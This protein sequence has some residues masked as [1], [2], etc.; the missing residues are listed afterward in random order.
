MIRPALLEWSANHDHLREVTRDDVVAHVKTLQGRERHQAL[1]ALRSLFAWA[2]KNGVIF[3][4]PTSQIKVGQAAAPVLQPL[5]PAQVARSAEAVT[6][7]AGRLAVALAA[8]HAA[9]PGSIRALQLDDTDLGN[10]RITIAGRTNPLDDLTRQLLLAWL[11]HRRR[12]WPNTANS[13]LIINM[14]TALATVPVS[15]WWIERELR[16]QAATLDRLRIDR[17]LE[18]ALTHGP[19]PLHLAEVFGLDEKTTMRYADSARA[20][21]EQAAESARP[22]RTLKGIMGG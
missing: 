8:V 16:G 4:N 9:R 11:E 5:L 20:R 10:R 12:R 19:D 13:H 18:E 2:K 14:N 21:L 3:R 15:S 17:Q 22:G 1:V 6:S 7:H